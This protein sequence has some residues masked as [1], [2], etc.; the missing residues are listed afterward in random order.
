MCFILT[1]VVFQSQRMAGHSGV[2]PSASLELQECVSYIV[3]SRDVE[4]SNSQ[5]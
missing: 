2:S 3:L 4:H 5:G 1:V